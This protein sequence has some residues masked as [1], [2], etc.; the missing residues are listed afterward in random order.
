MLRLIVVLLLLA[1]GLY[2]AW[3]QGHLAVFGLA[4]T[5]QTEPARMAQQIKPEAIRLLGPNDAKP[6]D[7]I[8]NPTS[9]ANSTSASAT[10]VKP[11]ECLQTPVLGER[12]AAAARK[13]L[14]L[15]PAGSW[16]LDNAEQAGRWI[17]YMGKYND[18]EV[19]A[20]KKSELRR[21]DVTIDTLQNPKLEPGISLGGHS[22]AAL[23][24]QELAI[25]NKR[26]VRTA[27]V[28]QEIAPAQ[29]Q[30]LRLPAV[31]D[32]LRAQ[33]EPVKTALGAVVLRSCN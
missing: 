25:L 29:G 18:P 10:P 31:D 17:V 14:E 33:L 15:L 3:T 2:F 30:I 13:A 5:P 21:L 12:V 8:T 20:K 26:G 19:L 4:P 1:N 28:V 9:N 27:K 6:V 23:A 7:N 32:A 11:L 16:S 22:S 24:N